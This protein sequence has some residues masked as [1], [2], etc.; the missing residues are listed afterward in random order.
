MLTAQLRRKTLVKKRNNGSRV[1]HLI[2]LIFTI[3]FGNVAYL[4]YSW[5]TV[6]T[7]AIVLD[8]HG[9]EVADGDPR[10]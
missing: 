10:V 8:D 3:G 1:I 9:A 6:D 2:R 7:V 5:I 4:V